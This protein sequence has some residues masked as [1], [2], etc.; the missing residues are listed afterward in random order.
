MDKIYKDAI[1][2]GV[3]TP[4]DPATRKPLC[5]IDRGSGIRLDLNTERH[6]NKCKWGAPDS[7]TP[8]KGQCVAVRNK[9]G[10]IWKRFIPD[11]YNMT[12]DLFAEGEIDFREHV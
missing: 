11:Y 9:L 5:G 8:E 6:C 12:C 3:I 2:A 10:A 1:K 7:N 4:S